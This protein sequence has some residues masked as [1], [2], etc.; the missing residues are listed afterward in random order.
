MASIWLEAHQSFSAFRKHTLS[1]VLDNIIDCGSSFK[2]V[3][4]HKCQ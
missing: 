1:C 3:A 2:Q 4:I